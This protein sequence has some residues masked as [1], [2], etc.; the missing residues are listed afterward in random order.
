M[1][2][3]ETKLDRPLGGLFLMTLLTIVWT[4]L[5]DYFFANADHKAVVITFGVVVV[6]FIF[7][8]LK[9]NKQRI[10]LPIE[11][12]IKEPKKEK[13]YLIIVCL[14]GIA[15]FITKNVLMNVNKDNLFIA[16]LALIVGLHFIPLAKVFERKFDYYI[17]IWTILTA[18]IG[19]ILISTKT[20]EY[21]IVNAFVCVFCA[22]STSSYGINMLNDAK[23]ILKNET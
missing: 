6:Y 3:K 17:G 5:A 10:N 7:S 18:I 1:A 2:D 8:Y 16:S 20:Y 4:I 22:I 19:L 11:I 12:K 21:H 14:E 23:K 9:F 13:A 15:I